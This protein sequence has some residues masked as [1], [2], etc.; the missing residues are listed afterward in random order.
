[1]S[2][3]EIMAKIEMAYEMGKGA[4][5]ANTMA[6]RTE[7]SSFMRSLSTPAKPDTQDYR[8]KVTLFRNMNYASPQHNKVRKYAVG[9]PRYLRQRVQAILDTGSSGNDM[10]AWLASEM[11]CREIE[12][13]LRKIPINT[14]LGQSFFNTI[15]IVPILEEVSMSPHSNFIILSFDVTQNNENILSEIK[16]NEQGIAML[17]VKLIFPALDYLEVMFEFEGKTLI[18]DATELVQALVELQAKI[19]STSTPVTPR[20]GSLTSFFRPHDN[21][22]PH[23]S[24]RGHAAH[25]ARPGS[26]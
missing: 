18:A 19:R 11:G 4:Q 16:L 23:P 26:D 20:S 7:M 22:S 10:P 25:D 21:H 15:A 13:P 2:K 24:S 3:E 12:N 6:N 17:W 14:V 5:E 9:V 1:M 8:R